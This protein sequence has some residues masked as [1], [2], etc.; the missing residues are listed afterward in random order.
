MCQ[1]ASIAYL[2]PTIC[3]LM[4]IPP[5]A[6]SDGA[7]LQ[8]VIR[9]A[10]AEIHGACVEKCLVYAPDAIGSNLYSR[11]ESYFAPVLRYTQLAVEVKSVFPPKTPVCFASMF[12]GA[13]PERHGIKVYE[14]PVLACETIFDILTKARKRVAIVAVK[15]S[16]I[17]KIFRGRPLDYFSENYDRQVTERVVA[18]L[19][20]NNH[21]FIVA[22]HQ[23]YDDVLHRTNPESAEALRAVRNHINSFE[24]MVAEVEKYWNNANR[25]IVFAPDHGAH[26][27]PATGK[28]TH[29]E[30]ISEDMDVTH[31]WG[32]ARSRDSV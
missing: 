23:E 27:D 5:P 2:T 4:R 7:E 3:R 17:D 1:R 16:S 31:F 18:L 13:A 15:D 8:S 29:G 26:I 12:T 14:K 28:G 21:D 22:Y 20:L 9:V 19:K 10:G 11:Y 25:L 24:R 32:V 30:D 6:V